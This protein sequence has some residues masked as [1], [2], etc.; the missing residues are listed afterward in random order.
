MPRAPTVCRGL[1]KEGAQQ[2]KREAAL[3]QVSILSLCVQSRSMEANTTSTAGLTA[4][5]ERLLRLLFA[6]VCGLVP[7]WGCWRW[8]G[9]RAS[10]THSS[11]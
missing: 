11:P 9:V 8:A 4:T 10:P 3:G 2:G 7:R 5:P 1:L 6:G